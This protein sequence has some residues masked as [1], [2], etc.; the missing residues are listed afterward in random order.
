MVSHTYSPSTNANCTTDESSI[1]TVN[2]LCD[3]ISLTS[4]IADEIQPALNAIKAT[5]ALAIDATQQSEFASVFSQNL[6][7]SVQ[8]IICA[9]YGC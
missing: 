9:P 8:A 6:P 5:K 1:Q 2:N 4:N 3:E 7:E